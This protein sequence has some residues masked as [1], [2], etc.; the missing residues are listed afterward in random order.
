LHTDRCL[1]RMGKGKRM[2][3]VLPTIEEEDMEMEGR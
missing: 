1:K 2:Y 3:Q